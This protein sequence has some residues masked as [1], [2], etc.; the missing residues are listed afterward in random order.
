MSSFSAKR[1]DGLLEKVIA[2][3]DTGRKASISEAG[4]LN[5]LGILDINWEAI[6]RP[7]YDLA[8]S[9]ADFE[10][11]LRYDP[12]G[13]ARQ[14]RNRHV[15]LVSP[16]RLSRNDANRAMAEDS[17]L[18]VASIQ[19]DVSGEEKFLLVRRDVG[20]GFCGKSFEIDGQN[21]PLPAN[22]QLT[23]D[24]EE[25]S[26]GALQTF[27]AKALFT[28][29]GK[30]ECPHCGWR[31]YLAKD[32]GELL[33]TCTWPMIRIEPSPTPLTWKAQA[34]GHSCRISPGRFA[35]EIDWATGVIKLAGHEVFSSGVSP[36]VARQLDEYPIVPAIAEILG[37]N[38]I[39]LAD[40]FP[41][42]ITSFNDFVREIK[43]CRRRQQLPYSQ[44]ASTSFS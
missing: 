33:V 4:R 2:S 36:D 5:W 6:C 28:P 9:I 38:C 8:E 18:A 21:K 27:P 16:A 7:C 1:I 13:N 37:K 35:I 22:R 12:E 15:P 25:K 44:T 30:V 24:F 11:Q 26:D 3:L 31:S 10:K 20:C 34:L 17:G 14:I 41:Q 19:I 23:L 32:A 29:N 42:P 43:S 40:I 39:D